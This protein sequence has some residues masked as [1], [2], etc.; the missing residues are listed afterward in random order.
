MKGNWGRSRES[1]HVSAVT[2]RLLR[3]K[4]TLEAH[5]YAAKKAEMAERAAELRQQNRYAK[6]EPRQS[7]DAERRA[8]LAMWELSGPGAD[9]GGPGVRQ[10][11]V[12][13]SPRGEIGF[14][15]QSSQDSC[16]QNQRGPEWDDDAGL[17]A[18]EQMEDHLPPSLAEHSAVLLPGPP[19][20]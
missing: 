19:I 16:A 5:E 6:S 10:L 3:Q 17:D 1:P 20:S 12:I 9:W 13:A 15:A 18:L 7:R 8:A 4:A 14:G 2:P 11:A